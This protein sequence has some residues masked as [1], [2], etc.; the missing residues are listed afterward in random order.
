MKKT[1]KYTKMNLINLPLHHDKEMKMSTMNKDKKKDKMMKM[2]FYRDQS[3]SSH[4]FKRESPE[5]IPSSTSTTISKPGESPALKLACLTFVNTIHS[6]L[7]L[8]L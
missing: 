5:I 2:M 6:S 7:A 3:K 4:E 8:K 1:R